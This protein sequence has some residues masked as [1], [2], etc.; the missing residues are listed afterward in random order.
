MQCRYGSEI[1]VRYLAILFMK[2]CFYYQG[3]YF[4]LMKSNSFLKGINWIGRF[5]L[6]IKLGNLNKQSRLTRENT[7]VRMTSQMADRGN[8]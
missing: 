2:K 7:Y 4:Q 5:C 3:A 6:V 8:L 1:P